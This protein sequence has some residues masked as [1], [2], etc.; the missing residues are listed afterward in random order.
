MTFVL[1]VQ[2]K[3]NKIKCCYYVI[4]LTDYGISIFSVN[5]SRLPI[6]KIKLSKITTYFSHLIQ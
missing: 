2:I 1:T 6:V 5:S 3:Y 4:D